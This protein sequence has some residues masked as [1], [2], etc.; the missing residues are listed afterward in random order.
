MLKEDLRQLFQYIASEYETYE[1]I[2]EGV[3]SLHSENVITD[4]EYNYILQEWDNMLEE[5]GL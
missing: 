5:F 2:K 3:R 1:E 4:D